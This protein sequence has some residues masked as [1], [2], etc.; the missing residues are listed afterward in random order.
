MKKTDKRIVTSPFIIPFFIMNEGCPH[1][2]VF[3]NQRI[4]AGDF[5]QKL[6]K[7]LFD[8]ELRASLTRNRDKSRKVEV[9][10][11][12]GSFTGADVVYQE[13]LLS[14]AHDYIKQGFIDSIRISTR[15]DD[16]TDDAVSLLKQYGVQTVEIGAQSFVD[17]VLRQAQRGH[18]AAD[19]TRAVCLLKENGFHTG[20]HLMAG[21]P[22]DTEEGFF[23]SLNETIRLKPDTVRIHPVL[24]LKETRLAEMFLR[25]D[26]RPLDLHQAV[27]MC[28]TAWIRLTE[29]D[30]GVIR[31]G[32][33]Q[34]PEMAE[35]DNILAGPIHP[36]F[37]SLV[38]SA[39]FLDY[40]M[41]LMER[42]SFQATKLKFVL[43]QRDISSFCG[44]RRGNLAEIKAHYPLR[45]LTVETSQTQSRGEITMMADS[46]AVYSLKIPG[47]H[48]E[49]GRYV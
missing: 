24:V 10:F 49:R 48:E 5:P 13:R 2:C 15:P 25:G 45:D 44:Y 12:G 1:R 31:M 9:A 6:T 22:A 18:V 4:S 37:G 27:Q 29:A 28:K 41:K 38:L 30:I 40:T 43:S 35:A 39:V 20:L 26:Y 3:C 46:G 19:T 32:L 21:L 33:H 14:W 34:T 42:L 23:H 36:A 7:D 47:I 16:V 17:D 8:G 11:Y